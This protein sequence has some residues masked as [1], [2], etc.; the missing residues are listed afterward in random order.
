MYKFIWLCNYKLNG[1]RGHTFGFSRD[2]LR[3]VG[4]TPI[5]FYFWTGKGC[6]GF[7][8]WLLKNRF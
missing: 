1:I 4:L 2:S 5:S 8:D 7:K 6:C 3:Q